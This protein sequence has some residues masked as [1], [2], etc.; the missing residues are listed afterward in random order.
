MLD[1]DGEKGFK[2]EDTME[3]EYGQGRVLF[4]NCDVTSNSQMKGTYM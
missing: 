2:L 3:K 1:I 4:I